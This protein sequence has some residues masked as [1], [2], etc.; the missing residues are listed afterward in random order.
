[1]NQTKYYNCSSSYIINFALLITYEHIIK[2]LTV[3]FTYWLSMKPNA[4][5]N[6]P[7]HISDAVFYLFKE[8]R[9]N[10]YVFYRC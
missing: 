7:L 9:N 10:R 4:N 3:C 8:V 1:M 6:A 2:R 5:A